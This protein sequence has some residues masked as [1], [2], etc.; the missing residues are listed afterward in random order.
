MHEKVNE[1]YAVKIKKSG[2]FM[3]DFNNCYGGEGDI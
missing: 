2:L 3:P 1:K